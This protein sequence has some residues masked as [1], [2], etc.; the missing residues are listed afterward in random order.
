MIFGKRGE[1]STV[2]VARD[3]AGRHCELCRQYP[4]NNGFGDVAGA[5]EAYGFVF[6][7][8]PLQKYYLWFALR[9][10]QEAY[11]ERGKSII[12]M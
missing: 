7:H 10:A 3:Y 4:F 8:E 9:Q 6:E 2:F 11:H 12:L 5:Y 1:L